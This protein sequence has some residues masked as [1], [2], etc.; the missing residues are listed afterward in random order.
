MN[1]SAICWA[2]TSRMTG[3]M[4]GSINVDCSPPTYQADNYQPRKRQNVQHK[5]QFAT[6]YIGTHADIQ[7]LMAD[8]RV[9][10]TRCSVSSDACHKIACLH[11]K[12]LKVG[13]VFNFKL[14]FTFP[15]RSTRDESMPIMLGTFKLWLDSGKSCAS[16]LQ[17]PTLTGGGLPNKYV[18][19][20]SFALESRNIRRINSWPYTSEA[21][22]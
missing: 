4:T 3:E 20:I 18:R 22:A 21:I 6:R 16:A 19:Q 8:W 17:A 14:K 5:T 15:R 7:D 13:N 11:F 2:Q 9:S 1:G 12:K 10:R